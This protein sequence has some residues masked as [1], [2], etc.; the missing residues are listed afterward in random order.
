VGGLEAGDIIRFG[1]EVQ[2]QHVL[3]GLFVCVQRRAAPVDPDC[4]ACTL[5]LPSSSCVFRYMPCFKAQEDGGALYFRNSAV[6]ESCLLK[7]NFLH[8]S[9]GE[10]DYSPVP[11]PR[12]PALPKCLRTG[13]SHEA[14]LNSERTTWKVRR[15]SRPHPQHADALQCGFPFRLFCAQADAFATASCDPEKGR[16]PGS[17][18]WAATRV[19]G[20]RMHLPYL[21]KLPLDVAGLAA[22]PGEVKHHTA[23]QL[24][25]VEPLV[26]CRTG[27]AKWGVPVRLRHVGSGKYLAVNTDQPPHRVY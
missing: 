16:R 3:S 24:W 12:D 1:A 5:S 19:G 17:G 7:G 27:P 10:M 21:K 6:L 23:K 25:C 18:Q 4:R 11:D 22:E 13:R 9:P 2:L 14:N 15:R 20:A 8:A 26:R